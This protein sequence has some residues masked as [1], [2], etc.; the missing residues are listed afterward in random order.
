MSK[1]V[2]FHKN[3]ANRY[4]AAQGALA[5]VALA[6]PALAFA[7]AADLGGAITTEVTGAKTTVNGLLLI[8]AGV[9]AAFLLWAMIKKARP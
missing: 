8:F 1:I 9:L 5:G 7:Q 2:K 6:S 3:I 4:Y